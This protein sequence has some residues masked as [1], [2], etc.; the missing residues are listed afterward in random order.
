MP[1]FPIPALS[2]SRDASIPRHSPGH[3]RVQ[4][5]VGPKAVQPPAAPQPRPAHGVPGGERGSGL[6]WHRRPPAHP[7]MPIRA[8][9]HFPTFPTTALHLVWGAGWFF[10]GG[11]GALKTPC[12]VIPA[13]PG[14]WKG[15]GCTRPPR[16]L[17]L[18]GA[19]PAAGRPSSHPWP[20]WRVHSQGQP[21]PHGVGAVEALPVNQPVH[22]VV[23]DLQERLQ[24]A[25]GQEVARQGE[26]AVP[27]GRRGR[28]AGNHRGHSRAERVLHSHVL[29]VS[30]VGGGVVEWEVCLRSTWPLRPCRDRHSQGCFPP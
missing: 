29:V 27:A 17:C 14:K 19:V 9:H 4:G 2:W 6:G 28:G 7:T 25:G 8:L 30:R 23:V 18:P 11:G 22:G 16:I 21:I 3:N 15:D 10:F 20:L 24:G 12:A 26:L 5:M 13:P 1:P